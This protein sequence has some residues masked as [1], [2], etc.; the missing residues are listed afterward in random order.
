MSKERDGEIGE[1]TGFEDRPSMTV[2]TGSAGLEVAGC[3]AKESIHFSSAQKP[4]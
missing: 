4:E 2:L 3:A 1:V